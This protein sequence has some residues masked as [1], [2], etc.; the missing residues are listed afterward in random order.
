MSKYTIVCSRGQYYLQWH[1]GG[2]NKIISNTV[3]VVEAYGMSTFHSFLDEWMDGQKD[4]QMNM[5][6]SMTYD[7]LLIQRK[8]EETYLV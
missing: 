6:I 2:Q 5:S 4:G 8:V 3:L 1:C 7:L